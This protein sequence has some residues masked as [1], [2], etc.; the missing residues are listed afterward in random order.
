MAI[1]SFSLSLQELA[2]PVPVAPGASIV[3]RGSL[4]SSYDGSVIDAA[5]TTWPASAPGGASVD[6]GG[7]IDLEAGGFE[8]VARDATAH[9]IRLVATGKHAPACAVSHVAS[10]C[11]LLRSRHL[12][13]SRLLGT[14]PWLAS[15]RGELRVEGENVLTAAETEAEAGA[16]AG[17]RSKE[18]AEHA[19]IPGIVCVLGL[20]PCLALGLR[21][22]RHWSS[23]ARRRFARLIARIDRAASQADPVL[24]KVLRPALSSANKAVSDR[25]LDPDSGEGLRLTAALEHLQRRLCTV[26][27]RKQRVA[28][29]R[30]ADELALEVQTAL[31]TAAEIANL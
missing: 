28:E 14:D 12:A 7:L 18:T 31:E 16:G 21:L 15:L 22:Y 13:H 2:T 10:P 6:A 25:R 1:E 8:I 17:A 30:V 9:E 11:L 29:R 4:Y 27:A 20:L 23:S 26:A 3:V 24:C 5:T 19:T